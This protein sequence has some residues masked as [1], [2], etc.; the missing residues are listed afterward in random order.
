V[1]DKDYEI[2]FRFT[3]KLDKVTIKLEP[4]MLTPEDVKSSRRRRRGRPA[5]SSHKKSR[6]DD[7]Q[8]A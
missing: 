3:G 2:P 7:R 8:Q 1:D 6:D 4:P 5:T